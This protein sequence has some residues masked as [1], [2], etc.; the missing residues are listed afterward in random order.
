MRYLL[1]NQGEAKYLLATTG[2]KN[3]APVILSTERPVISLGGYSGLDPVFTTQQLA[4]LVNKG[5]VRF[6]LIP[7][8]QLIMQ[9]M[10]TKGGASPQQLPGSQGDPPGGVS[11]G[12]PPGAPEG[13]VAQDAADGHP[14]TS[15]HGSARW[16][17]ENCKRVPQELWR[18]STFGQEQE[19]EEK[20]QEGEPSMQIQQALYNC[21]AGAS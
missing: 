10:P 4:D 17:R 14:A 1:A 15:Q 19:E 13:M 11:Q 20:K 6:F 5:E 16:V 9:M 8:K 18:S 7:E 21:G 3:T 2:S 12:A